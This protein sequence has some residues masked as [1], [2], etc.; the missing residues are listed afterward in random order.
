[1]QNTENTQFSALLSYMFWLIELFAFHYV[2]L[3]Y[4]L[5]SSVVNLRQFL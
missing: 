1:M 5:S 4:R 2:L 3:Y